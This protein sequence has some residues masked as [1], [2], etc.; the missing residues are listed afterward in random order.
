MK[1]SL[2]KMWQS[3]NF[4]IFMDICR[5]VLIAL[6]IIILITF[7]KEIEAVKLLAYDPC[8]I[9]MEKTGCNCFCLKP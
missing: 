5:I 4:Q 1:S 2:L 3:R 8:F 6:A 9:C 7:I